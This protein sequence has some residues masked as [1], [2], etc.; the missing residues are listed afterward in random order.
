MEK[1]NTPLT[2]HLDWVDKRLEFAQG[3]EKDILSLSKEHLL[4][5]LPAERDLMIKMAENAYWDIV[6]SG[7]I[8]TTDQ[9]EIRSDAESLFTETFKSYE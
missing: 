5:L 1:I 7:V 3:E 8:S 6:G 9:N 2:A 4:S